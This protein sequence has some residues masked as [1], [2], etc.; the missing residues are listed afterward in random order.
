MRTFKIEEYVSRLPLTMKLFH[1]DLGQRQLIKYKD[2][3]YGRDKRQYYRLYQGNNPERPLVFFIHGGGWW[4]GSPKVLTAIGKFF[5]RLGYTVVLPAYRLVPEYTYPRQINDI[6]RAFSH[7]IKTVPRECCN[8]VAV[9]GFSAGGELG[10]HLVFDRVMQDKYGIDPTVFKCFISLAGVLDF[11]KCRSSYAKHLIKNYLGQKYALD[12]ANPK[13]LIKGSI[14]IPVLCIH[15]SKDR[16]ID[17]QNAISFAETINRHGGSAKVH[18][19][20]GYHHSDIMELLIG[21]GK[22]ETYR[23]LDFIER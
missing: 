23:L 19:L 12:K 6:M 22:A 8:Q 3:R 2:V 7:V 1:H 9:I 4:H 18:R 13:E 5:Y 17:I 11:T 10:A 14:K 21:K 16:L 20:K 15:G